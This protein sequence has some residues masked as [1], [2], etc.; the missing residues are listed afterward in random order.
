MNHKFFLVRANNQ[1]IMLFIQ[2]TLFLEFESISK[3]A[4]HTYGQI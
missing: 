1:Q 2:T 4:S 3:V